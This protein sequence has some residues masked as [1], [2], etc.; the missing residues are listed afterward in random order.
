MS[1]LFCVDLCH[2]AAGLAASVLFCVVL[3]KPR[4]MSLCRFL[5]FWSSRRAK[6]LLG[7]ICGVDPI[8]GV[9]DLKTSIPRVHAIKQRKIAS[10]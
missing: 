3:A 6:L 10:R 4:L 9:E 2:L 7:R 8:S 1:V 5:Y